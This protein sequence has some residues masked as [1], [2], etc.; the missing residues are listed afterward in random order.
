MTQQTSR[1]I[2][3][4]SCDLCYGPCGH[5]LPLQ[6]GLMVCPDCYRQGVL[7]TDRPGS[8]AKKS[9]TPFEAGYQYQ[10]AL[11]HLAYVRRL[12]DG[13][14]YIANARR[15]VG[16]ARRTLRATRKAAADAS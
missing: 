2:P 8:R 13:P 15:A 3:A 12:G 6:T 7:N 4:V 1:P 10:Q 16:Y 14:A 5:L 11:E 9:L